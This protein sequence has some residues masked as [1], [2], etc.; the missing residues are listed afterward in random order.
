[1]TIDFKTALRNA[2]QASLTTA[3]QVA[4]VADAC[5]DPNRLECLRGFAKAALKLPAPPA[6]E[7]IDWTAVPVSTVLPE[8]LQV[9][10]LITQAGG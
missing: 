4:A 7:L 10:R 6:G 9:L 3:E 1:M 8:M 2:T 5:N